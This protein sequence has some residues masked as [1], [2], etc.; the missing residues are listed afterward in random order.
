MQYLDP[1][2]YEAHGLEADTLSSWI[3][4]ASALI[5]AHC[6]RTTLGVAQYA[7]RVRV[8]ACNTARLTYL[9]L[10]TVAPA[11]TPLI[12]V[13]VRYVMPRRGDELANMAN[14]FARIFG[15]PGTWSELDISN[16]DYQST[17]GELT[18]PINPLGLVYNEM[19]VTYNAGLAEIPDAV[20][21]ACVQIVRN[22]QATPALNV[23][24]NS[25]D[26]MHMEYF[27][28]TLIDDT[29]RKILAPY[30]AQRI[31]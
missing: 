1:S 15:L 28:N 5:D 2:E 31:A 24:A 6:R 16:I 25:L 7:E 26:Q 18:L 29:V 13:R 19:D 3:A 10:A 14:D 21:F 17:T 30:V 9:P 22:A 27:A 4:A 23:R 8:G 11:T 20:K 12:S